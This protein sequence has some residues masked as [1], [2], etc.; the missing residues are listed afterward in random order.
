ML[1]LTVVAIAIV[2]GGWKP[3]E[4]GR[5]LISTCLAVLVSEEI[6]EQLKHFF[7]RPWPEAWASS[8]P[9]WI[10][11]HTNGFNLFH[12]G[13]GWESFP[14]GHTAQVTALAAVIWLRLPRFRWLGVSIAALVAVALWATNYHFVGDIIAGAFL[15]AACGIG[16]VAVVCRKN[17]PRP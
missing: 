14:S 9:S 12:G 6:K 11:N 10:S 8:N 2:F 15:G 16:M 4:G 1:G 17:G 7:G 3:G 13:I 5:T